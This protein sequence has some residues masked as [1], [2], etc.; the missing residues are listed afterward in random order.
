MSGGRVRHGHA[1][2]YN[3]EAGEHATWVLGDE[4]FVN[5]EGIELA[6]FAEACEYH[7]STGRDVYVYWEILDSSVEIV[8]DYCL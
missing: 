1:Q 8:C 5:F 3:L 7:A 2:C 6:H 4:V